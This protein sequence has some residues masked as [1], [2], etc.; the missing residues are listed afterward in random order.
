[1]QY[2]LVI[3]IIII[4]IQVKGVYVFVNGLYVEMD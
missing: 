3:F 2:K 1:M 4:N